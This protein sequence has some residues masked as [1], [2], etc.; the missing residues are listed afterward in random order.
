MKKQVQRFLILFILSLPFLGNAQL[1]E[2]IF[3][4]YGEGSANNKYLELYNGT[5]TVLN[6]GNYTIWK[7]TN[8][9]V[10]FE[11][12]FVL[13]GVLEDGDTYLIVNQNADAALSALRDTTGPVDVE[14]A[15]FNGNE[16][17]ALVKIT[18]PNPEDR[19]ILDVIGTE[20]G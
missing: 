7:I 4:E 20:S 8:D 12:E 14:F 16:A 13:E 5:G 10:W 2:L 1:S 15:L 19:E 6:L 18:G 9:G 11:R 3:S 17:F